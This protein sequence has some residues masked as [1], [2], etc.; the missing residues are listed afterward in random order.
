MFTN[1]VLNTIIN[2]GRIL[3]NCR[4]IRIIDFK[5]MLKPRWTNFATFV[6]FVVKFGRKI[7][8]SKARG[9]FKY[10]VL[11]MIYNLITTDI[12]YSTSQLGYTEC[13]I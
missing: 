5:Q 4:V 10:I 3:Y 13:C 8:L 2:D 6:Y 1:C 9:Y 7:L 12:L 11:M